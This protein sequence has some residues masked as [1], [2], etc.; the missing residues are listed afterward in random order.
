MRLLVE[1]CLAN[2]GASLLW[3]LSHHHKPAQMLEIRI[4]KTVQYSLNLSRNYSERLIK[5]VIAR[6]PA[7]AGRR[8]NLM[9]LLHPA[10]RDSQ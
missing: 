2:I 1:D 4:S 7:L 8:G 9:G 5:V 6:S 3:G 10:K